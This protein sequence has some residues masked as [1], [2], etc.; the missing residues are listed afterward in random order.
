ML[1]RRGVRCGERA[2]PAGSGPA[3]DAVVYCLQDFGWAVRREGEGCRS[4][5]MAGECGERGGWRSLPGDVANRESEAAPL[6]DL[7]DVEEV[8]ANQY[9]CAGGPGGS[10]YL[11]AGDVGEP[12]RQQTALERVG[13]L[14]LLAEQ[15]CSGHRKCCAGSQVLGEG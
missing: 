6:A 13:D 12:D 11:Q 8:A 3:E 1:Y 10:G 4:R 5:G 2:E 14:L 9:A 7:P 15:P